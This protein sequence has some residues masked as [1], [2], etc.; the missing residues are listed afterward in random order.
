MGVDDVVSNIDVGVGIAWE[1]AAVGK[2]YN[3]V[4]FSENK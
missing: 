1:E 3:A 4:E 2:G